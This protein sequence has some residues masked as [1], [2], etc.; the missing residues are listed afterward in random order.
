M[1]EEKNPK[2]EKPV[3]KKSNTYWE[4][5]KAIVI[6]V[7]LALLIRHFLFEPYLVEG[8]SMY[9]TLHDGERLFVNKTVNYVGELKRGDIV[10]INGDS[11]KVH[12]VKRLIGK[13]G[14]TVEMKDDTLYINGKKIDES[15]L[16]N[17]KKD[18]KKL[19]VNLTGD[20]GP[21]KVPKGKYFVMGD[22]RLN[23]MDSRNGL[24]LISEDRIVGTSKFVFFPFNEMRQTK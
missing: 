2:T 22:N 10:I 7:V 20:F 1:T 8:S 18:A 12:Y 17:N 9:P 14:E 11:S 6:A 4:W 13:P 24:G 19:G 23:S 15:Y 16:S 5:A 21:V 3:K